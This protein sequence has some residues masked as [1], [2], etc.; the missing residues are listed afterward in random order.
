MARFREI[1]FSAVLIVVSPVIFLSAVELAARALRFGFEPEFF[2]RHGGAWVTNEKYGWR[3]FPRE[4]ARTPAP[5]VVQE[6]KRK[7]RLFVLGESAAMGFPDPAYGLAA[8]LRSSLGE[9]WE[10]INAAMTAINSHAI[11]QIASECARL[12]PDVFVIYIGNNEVV[13]P[14]G[15]GTVFGNLSPLPVIRTQIWLKGWRSGQTFSDWIMPK[16]VTGGEWRG[17]ELFKDRTVAAGDPQLER[18]YAHFRANARDIVRAGQKAG[19][20][21]VISTVAVN[22]RDCPPFASP[23]GAAA[24]AYAAGDYAKARDLDQLRF[25]A[26][27]RI[28]RTI[29]EV[30]AETGAELVDAERAIEPSRKYFWEHVHLRPEGNALLASSIARQIAPAAKQPSIEVSGWDER[31]LYRDVRALVSRAPFTSAHLAAV[32]ESTAAADWQAAWESW[33]RRVRAWP[34]D[35]TAWERHAEMAAANGDFKSAETLYRGML[36]HIPLGSWHTGLA[37]ALLKQ[38]QFAQAEVEY[39]A[40]LAID[41]RFAGAQLGLGVVRAAAGDTKT[42]EQEIRRAIALQPGLAE[43]HNSLGRLLEAQGKPAEAEQEYRAAIERQPELTAAHYNRA[44]ILART[45]REREA[46]AE[47][48]AAIKLDPAFASAHYDLGVLLARLGAVDAAEPHYAEALRL[49]PQNADAWNNWGTALARR[50]KAAD[51]R[52]KFE[53]ALKANPQHAAARRNL[54]LLARP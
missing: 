46:I 29:R 15:A 9:E 39:K 48:E 26:D 27:S 12:Q 14:F 44:G 10:V 37:E 22:L 23:D 36:H 47:L 51:A 41:D 17:L 11:R 30:A 31:R 32:G 35:F 18:V 25:R 13:G 34:D 16:P 8:Q 7:K 54:E 4:I 33:Q 1:V 38:G 20:R 49:N 19:A 2:I 28:N 24:Q 52:R 45:N 3:W 21:V 42:A 40:A 5:A 6:A 53:Q 43:A 50:G